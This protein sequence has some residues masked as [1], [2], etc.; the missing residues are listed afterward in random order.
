M[1]REISASAILLLMLL[2]SLWNLRQIDTLTGEIEKLL[3]YS[4]AAAEQSDFT[5]AEDAALRALDIWLHADGY[6][7]IFIRHPEIDSTSDAFYE[8]LA[9]IGAHESDALGAA[10]GK[11]LYH[12]HSIDSMEHV[13]LGSLL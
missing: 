4:S 6:T 9:A 12:L 1:R 11:L 8:L 10:Y 7:H 2:F 3:H 5:T 13:S